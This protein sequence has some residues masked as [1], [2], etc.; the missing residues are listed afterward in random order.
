[1][2]HSALFVV[3][4]TLPFKFFSLAFIENSAEFGADDDNSKVD[5]YFGILQVCVCVMYTYGA[6]LTYGTYALADTMTML[7][8][9]ML[10]REP[11]LSIY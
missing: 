2:Q 6:T 8:P 10:P 9:R 7:L 3:Y 4:I 5:T 11:L 1:M